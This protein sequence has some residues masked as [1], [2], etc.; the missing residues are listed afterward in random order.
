[1]LAVMI[2]TV[3]AEEPPDPSAQILN[4]QARLLKLRAEQARLTIELD[5]QA[6]LEIA[7][8]TELWEQ[9]ITDLKAEVEREIEQVTRRFE[10]EAR[11]ILDGTRRDGSLRSLKAE[12]DVIIEEKW[13]WFETESQMRRQYLQDDIAEI[14]RAKVF[15]LNS[16][17]ALIDVIESELR[18]RLEKIGVSYDDFRE[19]GVIE[20]PAVDVAPDPFP[21]PD[22]VDDLP[23]PEIPSPEIPPA[24]ESGRSRGFFFNSIS[25]DPNGLNKTL[26][27]TTLAV[28]GTLITL[29]ATGVQLLKGN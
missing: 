1:M 2:L 22:E 11:Q 21:T 7:A 10:F 3:S 29:A 26:D 16:I 24:E 4:F 14:E 20:F 19:T 9:A 5:R 8:V 25:A 23:I 12:L 6:K 17:L 13:D 15:E 27:P 28:I 18:T